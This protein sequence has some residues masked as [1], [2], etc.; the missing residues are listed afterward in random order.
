MLT[1]REHDHYLSCRRRDTDCALCREITG[2]VGDMDL[3]DLYFSV[4]EKGASMA[5]RPDPRPRVTVRVDQEKLTRID[6]LA[7]RDRRTRQSW[8]EGLIEA[9]LEKDAKRKRKAKVGQS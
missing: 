9:E 5:Q 4:K 1:D 7:H 8:I 6:E 3:F 2:L